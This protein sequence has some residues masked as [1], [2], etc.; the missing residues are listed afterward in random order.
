MRYSLKQ[1]AEATGRS[2]PTIWRAIQTHKI[3][4]TKDEINGS[5]TIDPAELHRV[6]PPVSNAD[7]PPLQNGNL[8]QYEMAPNTHEIEI[9]RRD[10]HHAGEKIAALKENLERERET[11]NDLRRRL[12]AEGE[13]RRRTQAQL[14]ALLTDQRERSQKTAQAP[15]PKRKWFW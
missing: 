9:L 2:K 3:S 5:W 13:E 12:D 8:K 6:F 14:T 7:T 15:A 10:L 11:T 4:A 1:A